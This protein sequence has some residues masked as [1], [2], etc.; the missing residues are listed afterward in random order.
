VSFGV[1]LL[2]GIVLAA[3][4]GYPPVRD[5]AKLHPGVHWL[6]V[7][8]AAVVLIAVATITHV[9]VERQGVAWGRA[10]LRRLRRGVGVQA[11]LLVQKAV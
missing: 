3:A 9:Y 6:V 11:N 4:F 2:Q 10:L 5:L 7:F 8:L 1:Y